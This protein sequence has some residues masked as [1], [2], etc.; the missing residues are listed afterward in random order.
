MTPKSKAQVAEYEDLYEHAERTL[1]Q[2]V[3]REPLVYEERDALI[4][5]A[6]ATKEARKELARARLGPVDDGG[7]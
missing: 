1:R 5:A 4:R 7:C 2:I 6:E 3:D